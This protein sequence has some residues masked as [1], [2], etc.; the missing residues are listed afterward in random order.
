MPD[1]DPFADLTKPYSQW[2]EDYN[3]PE[4]SDEDEE[5]LS[6]EEREQR[7]QALIDLL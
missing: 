4:E 3:L 6:E 5:D 2:Y 1:L 7:R